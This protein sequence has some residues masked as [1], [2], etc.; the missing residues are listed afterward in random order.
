MLGG[1]GVEM[2]GGSIGGVGG[3]GGGAGGEVRV[4]VGV[5]VVGVVAVVGAG[6]VARC[7]PGYWR[8]CQ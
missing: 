6:L 5:V 7:L 1:G 8:G 3:C 4:A 2:D